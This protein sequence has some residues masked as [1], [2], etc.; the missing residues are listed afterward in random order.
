MPRENEI[1]EYLRARRELRPPLDAGISDIGVM[2]DGAWVRL[3]SANGILP[4]ERLSKL[5]RRACRV[6]TTGPE[7]SRAP[8]D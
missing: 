1:G 3:T 8:D 4:L 5:S 6:V 2:P 7:I